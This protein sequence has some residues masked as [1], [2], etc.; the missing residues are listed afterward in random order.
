M[1][2]RI[3]LDSDVVISS[4]ISSSGAAYLLINQVENLK[5]HI[6]NFSLKELEVVTD[7]LRIERNQLMQV[8]NGRCKTIN[9]KESNKKLKKKYTSYVLDIN[10]AHIVAGSKA[11]GVRFLVSY[12]LKHYKLDRIKTDFGIIVLTPAQLLQYLRSL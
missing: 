2:F 12:N 3:F 10:D 6:S 9:L 1:A 11:A 8:I 4:L 7:R 5:L